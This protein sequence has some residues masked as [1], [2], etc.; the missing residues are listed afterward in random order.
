MVGDG[1]RLGN[2]FFTQHAARLK[3]LRTSALGQYED[4]S[5]CR[6]PQKREILKKSEVRS[7]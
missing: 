3:T 2:V 6:S 7:P 1:T 4:L 5:F